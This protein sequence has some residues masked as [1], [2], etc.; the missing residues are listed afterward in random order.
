[1]RRQQNQ[2]KIIV[3]KKTFTHEVG[4]ALKLSHPIR[5]SNLANH[6]YSGLPRSIMNQGYPN[7]TNVSSTIVIH[8]V[9]NIVSKWGY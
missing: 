8:D 6:I 2:K 5:N 1:M 4:H 3:A 9:G 7:S